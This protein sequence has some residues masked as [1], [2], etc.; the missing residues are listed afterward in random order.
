M[1]DD[2]RNQARKDN[3]KEE[4]EQKL[5]SEQNQEQLLVEQQVNTQQKDKLDEDQNIGTEAQELSERPLEDYKDK[6]IRLQAEFANFARQKE[7][8]VLSAT[9]FAK[10]NILLRVLEVI[11]DIEAYL[12]QEN[13]NEEV[14]N[15]LNILLAKLNLL[16]T[17]E[18]VTVVEI[19][20]G[21]DFDYTIAEVV[22]TTPSQDDSQK[23]KVAYVIKKCYKIY[24]K[25]LRTAKIIVFK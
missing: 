14:K 24:D 15:I 7:Q 13:I 9:K 11:D 22:D 8:E 3:Q 12:A 4:V 10:N 23:G 16:I 18:G 6:Y 20:P 19:N 21:D 17:L 5:H 1:A 2:K 25:V